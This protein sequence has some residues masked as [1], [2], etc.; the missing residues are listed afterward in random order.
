MDA[1][2]TVDPD[3]LTTAFNIDGTTNTMGIQLSDFNDESAIYDWADIS[4]VR[5]F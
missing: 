5:S 4:S 3:V 1:T 2:E